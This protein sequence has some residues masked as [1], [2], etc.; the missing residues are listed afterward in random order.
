MK[1]VPQQL[2][3]IGPARLQRL[4][5]IS[6]T[7][8][9]TLDLKQLLEMIIDTATD[10]TDTAS[11]SILLVEPDSGKLYFAATTGEKQPKEEMV[12]PLEG[13]I[14]GWIVDHGE[15]LI[16][17]EVPENRRSYPEVDDS[18]QNMLG[19]PLVTKQRVI[20]VLETVNKQNGKLYSRRDVA[21]L[22]A[23]ASQAAVAIE[24]ARL[25]Q[26]TDLIA[27]FMHELK[28]PLMALTA[29]SEILARDELPQKQQELLSMIQQE[30]ARLSK[31]AQDF[32][33]L[34]RLESGRTH[35]TYEPVDL[36]AILYDVMRLQEPQAAS[37]NITVTVDIPNDLPV[38]M[39]DQNRLKQ[40]LLNLTSNAIKYNVDGGAIKIVVRVI[41]G[42]V[43]IEVSDTGVGIAPEFLEHLFER[44]YRVPDREG[45]TEGAGL[46]LS[47][48]KRILLEHGGRIEVRSVV[49]QGS[50]FCCY[51]PSHS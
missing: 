20:G 12:V 37:R 48:A 39:G 32:L 47:I 40:V 34:A 31:L 2:E 33:E 28:T 11:A 4:L 3:A 1:S 9:S 46:G 5:E 41:D 23:L 21:V 49:G 17:D 15:A 7:L 43:A 38:V 6:E 24:N 42:E 25:F 36:T 29:A 51:L 19:V 13:T 35:L 8:S 27:E 10:L 22:Q 45:F 26:Q 16:L 30:T 44:F 18:T 50:T 14:A